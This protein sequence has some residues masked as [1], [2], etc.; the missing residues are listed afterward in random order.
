MRAGLE[1]DKLILLLKLAT[2]FAVFT[3]LTISLI[4][5]IFPHSLTILTNH[6]EVI[7]T[8]SEYVIWLPWI[9]VFN[10]LSYIFDGYI[11]GLQKSQF[12]RNGALFA[13]I[14][15][16]LPL[17]IIFLIFHSNHI[18]WLSLVPYSMVIFSNV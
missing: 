5:S 14:F 10:A 3:A 8:F 13:L 4:I 12:V 16:L 2:Y 7:Q 1:K 17:E 11:V 15:G 9:F 6:L 18:L